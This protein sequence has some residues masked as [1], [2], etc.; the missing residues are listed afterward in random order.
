MNHWY[1]LASLCHFRISINFEVKRELGTDQCIL[2]SLFIEKIYFR[3]RTSELISMTK[4]FTES[5]LEKKWLDFPWPI[6]CTLWKNAYAFC[7]ILKYVYKQAALVSGKSILKL[8]FRLLPVDYIYF[9][10]TNAFSLCYSVTSSKHVFFISD[11]R[12]LVI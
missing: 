10:C 5:E 11:M 2:A 3:N 8:K 9:N 1:P 4:L 7:H 12:G 6:F